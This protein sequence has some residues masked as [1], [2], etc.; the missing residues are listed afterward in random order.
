MAKMDKGYVNE[1][2]QAQA[3]VWNHIFNFIN[4]MSLKCSVDLGIPDAI[5][6]HGKPMTVTELVA[7][8]PTLDRT[9]AGNI[10]RL[11]RILVHSGFFGV[12]EDGYVLT[13]A[14]RLL[15]KDDPLSMVPFV[16][17]ML[18]PMLTKPW[19]FLGIWFESNDRSPFDTAYGKSFWDY[20]FPATKLDNLMKEGLARDSR[21]VASVLIDRC[22]GMFEGLNSL[23]DVG[24][25]TGTV[26]KA[27]ADAFPH[28]ECTVFDLPQTVAALQD[29]GNLK[30]V[31][32]NMFEQV[33]PADAVLL[34]WVLCD[35]NDEECLKILKQ[36]RKAVKE[37]GKVIIVDLVLIKNEKADDEASNL[38][39]TQ[40]LFD[41][42]VTMVLVGGKERG[43]EE[44]A[45][46][47]SASG[48]SRY[49]IAPV[50]GMRSVIEVYP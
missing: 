39:E 23:V 6:N 19:D 49:E 26:G 33:P 10:Y 44:W 40:L 45:K 47:F 20:D 12:E 30:Y 35:W 3:H 25:S 18:D 13:S 14:S 16:E 42:M 27:I 37:G 41:I 31:G 9:K 48:F 2:L 8:L 46:L 24:G 1:L 21:L 15:L 11:M 4:S 29:T 17:S 32:G 5:H 43:E 28:L 36:C 38:I 34:K 7:A 50:L 22:R